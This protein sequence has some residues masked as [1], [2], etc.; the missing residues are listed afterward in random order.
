MCLNKGL[1]VFGP[2]MTVRLEQRHRRGFARSDFESL[3]LRYK[4]QF[5]QI[6][7]TVEFAQCGLS[8]KKPGHPIHVDWTCAKNPPGGPWE[9]LDPVSLG[10]V[11]MLPAGR[12]PVF[13][14]QTVMMELHRLFALAQDWD[15]S[16][17]AVIAR[18]WEYLVP[19]RV[20]CVLLSAWVRR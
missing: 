18:E 4:G 7:V 20:F 10:Q 2:A 14:A 5:L 17:C 12:D 6:H 1:A 3:A 11:Q 19:V 16:R 8:A 9:K 15:W 13:Q